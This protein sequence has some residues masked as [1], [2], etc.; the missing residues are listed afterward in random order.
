MSNRA[1]CRVC[2]LVAPVGGI[3][4]YGFAARNSSARTKWWEY[5]ETTFCF[6]ANKKALSANLFQVSAERMAW[7]AGSVTPRTI[8]LRQ[9]TP[10]RALFSS[11]R[12]PNMRLHW[13]AGACAA[14][15]SELSLGLKNG[16]VRP[17]GHTKT[18]RLA[19]RN[20][21]ARALSQGVLR[22]T[23]AAHG[24]DPVKITLP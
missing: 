14:A 3:K 4:N 9:E 7:F 2:R 18:Y 12:A 24:V 17:I 1:I 5:A 13:R 21:R 20:R 23:A 6:S 8:D 10:V 19:S 22:I 15:L 16:L 11:A